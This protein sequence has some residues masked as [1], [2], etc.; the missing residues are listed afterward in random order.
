[1]YAYLTFTLDIRMVYNVLKGLSRLP[2]HLE[3]WEGAAMYNIT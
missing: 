2:E 3:K 1:V